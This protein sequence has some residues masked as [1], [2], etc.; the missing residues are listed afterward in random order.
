MSKK[1]GVKNMVAIIPSEIDKE[2]VRTMMRDG[3][4]LVEVLPKD[5]YT[6]MHLAGAVSKPLDILDRLTV[7]GLKWDEPVIVYCY[8][9]Q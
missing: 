2:T 7:E 4:Q 5:A 1:E 6:K 8:D 3:A 9:Y